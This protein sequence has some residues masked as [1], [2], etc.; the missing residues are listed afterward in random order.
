MQR[1]SGLGRMSG[2]P[3]DD[4]TLNDVIKDAAS[5]YA[6]GTPWLTHTHTHTQYTHTHTEREREKGGKRRSKEGKKKREQEVSKNCKRRRR[7]E[8]ENVEWRGFCFLWIC[9]F[10]VFLPFPVSCTAF[11]SSVVC[12]ACTWHTLKY[13]SYETSAWFLLFLWSLPSLHLHLHPRPSPLPL[14]LCHPFRFRSCH[15]CLNI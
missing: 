8:R 5:R 7:S 1:G 6:P 9:G 14:P 15:F 13:I 3:H 12:V 2:R 10:V 11:L 4:L